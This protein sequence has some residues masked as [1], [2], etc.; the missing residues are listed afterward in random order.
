MFSPPSNRQL[1]CE[2]DRLEKDAE[3]FDEQ[4]TIRSGEVIVSQQRSIFAPPHFLRKT[5]T[6]QEFSML[7]D[8]LNELW[9]INEDHVGKR[10]REAEVFLALT[11]QYLPLEKRLMDWCTSYFMHRS[12]SNRL[13]PLDHND[14][15]E[16]YF[17]LIKEYMNIFLSLG[18]LRNSISYIFFAKCTCFTDWLLFDRTWRTMLVSEG[19]HCWALKHPPRRDDL[20]ERCKAI[21]LEKKWLLGNLTYFFQKM[22]KG[23]NQGRV[24]ELVPL[25]TDVL[26]RRLKLL[27]SDVQEMRPFL[28]KGFKKE[29]AIIKVSDELF[30]AWGWTT[31]FG[32]ASLCVADSEK[33]MMELIATGCSMVLVSIDHQGLLIDGGM[34][35]LTAETIAGDEGLAVASYILELFHEKLFAFYDKIDVNRIRESAKAS[36]RDDQEDD[37]LVALT[38]QDL[39]QREPE[40]AEDLSQPRIVARRRIPGLRYQRLEALL[41]KKLGVEA[42]QGKGSERTFYRQGGKKVA[43]GHHKRNDC[44]PSPL[45]K[46][47]LKRLGVSVQEFWDA[48]H[49]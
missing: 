49:D 37:S 14:P 27:I 1:S 5:A 34:P 10:T 36:D 41:E 23:G 43:I 30:L 20:W 4:L 3:R 32:P 17:R 45:V 19:Q 38:C 44:V 26:K 33:R 9:S 18:T 24:R 31:Q 13:T 22:P 7:V 2:A 11:E 12:S 46:E 25:G 16:M 35:W 29:K 47:I 40:E 28:I 8:I 42:M 39:A 48:V 6:P 21:L 15:M